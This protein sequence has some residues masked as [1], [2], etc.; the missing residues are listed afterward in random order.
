MTL[1]ASGAISL[2]DVMNE[3]RLVN[4]GRAYPISLGDSDVR[5]LAGVPSGTIGLSNL[6]GKSSYIPLN[7]IGNNSENSVSSAGGAGLVTCNPSVS[8]T[9]GSGGNTYAWSFTS[10]P[11]SCS[12]GFST[13]AACAVSH[14]YALNANGGAS[15]TLQCIVTDNTG[16][17]ATASGITATLGWSN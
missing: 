16:H 17:S 5:A 6:Y 3:I 15:A 7:V 2:T 14:G 4:S 13:S 11:N 1:P 8:V 9:G 10:N 12:L